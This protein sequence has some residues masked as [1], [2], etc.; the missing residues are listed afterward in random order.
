M[1]VDL[2][3]PLGPSSPKIDPRGIARS[4]PLRA[5]LAATILVAG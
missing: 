3:A 1:K 4:T 2:P 5:V